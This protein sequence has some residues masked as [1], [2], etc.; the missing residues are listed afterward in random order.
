MRN[1]MARTRRAAFLFILGMA[2]LFLPGFMA[3][4]AEK[5]PILIDGITYQA[6]EG[7]TAGRGIVMVA[8]SSFR[9]LREAKPSVIGQRQIRDYISN[10]LVVQGTAADMVAGALT[11]ALR[12]RGIRSGA[13][14][15][16][17]LSE[18]TI[19]AEGADIVVGGEI[20]ALWI[21]VLS[22]PFKVK[23]KS[24]AQ[25]RVSVADV[26]EK[27]VLRTVN[28]SSSLEQE[29]VSYSDYTVQDLFGKTLSSAVDQLLNDEELKKKI[30]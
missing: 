18:S 11:E 30:R 17:D 25:L 5:G 23:Y 28:L 14:A 27:K 9:D 4:C 26:K 12:A 1:A 16:W 19:N 2:M 24:I 7:L 29:Q 6:P 10:D 22:Q 13:A 21:E 15:T 3:G 8:V 20:K